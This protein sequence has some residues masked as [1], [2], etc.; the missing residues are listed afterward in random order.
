MFK[1]LPIIF[2]L[3]FAINSRS[4]STNRFKL[5]TGYG[6]YEGFSIGATSDF[7]DTTRRF[8]WSVGSDRFYWDEKFHYAVTFGYESCLLKC[9]ATHAELSRWRIMYDIMFW[10]IQ[11]SYFR[12]TM[13]SFV[14]Q[15][16]RQFYFLKSF[17]FQAHFGAAFNG[18]LKGV[19]IRDGAIGTPRQL[20]FNF[21]VY[22][23]K[24]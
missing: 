10:Q 23:T 16:G 11:D 20:A 2:I 19:Q 21:G 7:K 18:L 3:F 13:L 12:F 17:D 6:Y 5:R 9:F 22:F 15:L 24:K 4:Q 8:T 14:P 1:V